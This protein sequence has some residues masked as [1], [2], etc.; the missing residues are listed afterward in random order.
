MPHPVGAFQGRSR[1]ACRERRLTLY[2]YTCWPEYGLPDNPLPLLDF[3]Q[4]S[5]ER[6]TA[7]RG[8]LLVISG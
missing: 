4:R 3:I 5:S 8:P 7:A 2:Q 6:E 1:T